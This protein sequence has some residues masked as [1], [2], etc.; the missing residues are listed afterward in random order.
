ME[1]YFENRLKA[2]IR[3]TCKKE[4]RRT[5]ISFLDCLLKFSKKVL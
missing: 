5:G 4:M 1:N 3:Q 2:I